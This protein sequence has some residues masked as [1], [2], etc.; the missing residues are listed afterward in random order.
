[1]RQMVGWV[2]TMIAITGQKVVERKADSHEPAMPRERAVGR[3]YK[4]HWVDQVWRDTAKCT[5]FLDKLSQAK[6]IP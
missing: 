5:T 1:M 3:D 4:R 2:D 6:D